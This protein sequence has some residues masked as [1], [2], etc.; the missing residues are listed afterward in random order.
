MLKFKKLKQ[1]KRR[2]IKRFKKAALKIKNN[3][4]LKGDYYRESLD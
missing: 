4:Q 1:S 2:L 3:Y